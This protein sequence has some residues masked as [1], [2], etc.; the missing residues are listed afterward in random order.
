MERLGWAAG[1]KGCGD[2]LRCKPP[3]VCASGVACLSPPHTLE[4][5]SLSLESVYTGLFIALS[6]AIRRQNNR[7]FAPAATPVRLP[8]ILAST[9]SGGGE[10]PLSRPRVAPLPPPST[11]KSMNKKSRNQS[12]SWMPIGLGLPPPRLGRLPLAAAGSRAGEGLPAGGS[13]PPPHLNCC[14]QRVSV[15]KAVVA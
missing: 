3:A 9:V 10:S 7:W 6:A 8:H 1:G 12:F 2:R 15:A 4:T 5:P 14:P 11:P 13:A